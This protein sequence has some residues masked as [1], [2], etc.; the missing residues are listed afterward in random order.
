MSVR[1]AFTPEIAGR[2]GQYEDLPREYVKWVG[3]KGLSAEWAERYWAAHWSLPSPQQGFEM[4]HRGIITPDELRL[5]LRALDIMPFWRDKLIQISYNPLTRVDIRRMYNLDVL[6]EQD[7]YKCYLDIG[8]NDL[9][10]KRLTEFTIK[11]KIAQETKTKERQQKAVIKEI[12][13]WTA[14]QTLSFLKRGLITQE[15]ARHELQLLGY[16]EERINVYLASTST[17]T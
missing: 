12:S 7:V 13:T 15:R 5:L 6:S 17:L 8:Y 4:L 11:L 10:A 1:E 3:K 9:N 16:N 14:S 2:F